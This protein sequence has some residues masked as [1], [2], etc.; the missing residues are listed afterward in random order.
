MKAGEFPLFYE[1]KV[2]LWFVDKSKFRYYGRVK[3]FDG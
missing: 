3:T 2:H 1:N